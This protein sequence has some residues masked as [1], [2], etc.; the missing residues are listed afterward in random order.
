MKPV[1]ELV[2]DMKQA[3]PSLPVMVVLILLALGAGWL[4]GRLAAPSSP[5]QREA[6]LPLA[7]LDA[8]VSDHAAALDAPVTEPSSLA[9]NLTSAAG[10]SGEPVRRKPYLGMRA[11]AFNKGNVK[12]VK[13]SEIFSD[14]PAAQAGLRS[15]KDPL[16][17]GFP[18]VKGSTGHVI[19]G[20]NRRAIRSEDHLRKLL[21]ESAAGDTVEFLVV[22]ANG[23]F[24]E[25]IPVTLGTAPERSG[26]Q[27][28][29]D[30]Q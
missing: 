21:A 14:S 18:K 5:S 24:Y 9:E 4:G 11:N 29:K 22:F 25:L 20:A 26:A 2:E 12:G 17:P 3:L 15:D 19:I 16:P 8:P 23:D 10:P 28:A 6:A 7:S 30:E 1:T 27:S 13:I